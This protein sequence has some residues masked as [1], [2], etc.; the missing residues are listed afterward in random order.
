MSIQQSQSYKP[1]RV[2]LSR[3]VSYL[4]VDR[5]EKSSLSDRRRFWPVFRDAVA[6]LSVEAGA[7][8][9]IEKR[10]KNRDLERKRDGGRRWGRG[11]SRWRV[12]KRIKGRV[13]VDLPIDNG[14][15]L[16]NSTPLAPPSIHFAFSPPV[17]A[18]CVRCF[19]T[20]LSRSACR[21]T[22]GG[23]G[24]TPFLAAEKPARRR[25]LSLRFAIISSLDFVREGEK[26]SYVFTQFNLHREI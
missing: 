8:R 14:F 5:S 20:F 6:L 4:P 26:Y 11:V 23:G 3:R 10:Q 18:R 13:A 17:R 9:V 19:F 2:W 24:L 16:Y 7:A 1:R 21:V 25:R 22:H 15:H 12:Q